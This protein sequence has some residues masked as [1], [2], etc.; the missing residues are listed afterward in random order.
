M[1]RVQELVTAALAGIENL[2]PA[3]LAEELSRGDVLVVDVREPAE[4]ARGTLPGAVVVPRGLLEFLAEGDSP[5]LHPWLVPERRV[6]VCSAVG[7]RSALAATTLQA[8]GYGDV[9]HLA[10]GVRGWAEEG[11]PLT[12]DQS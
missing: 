10:G 11:R 9:A 2:R 12:A 7:A 1:T 6:V 8:L 5:R 3:E 4:A